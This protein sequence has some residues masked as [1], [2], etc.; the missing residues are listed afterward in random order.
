MSQQVLHKLMESLEA[1]TLTQLFTQ[2]VKLVFLFVMTKMCI[3][4]KTNT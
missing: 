2:I 4:F 3:T 1:L